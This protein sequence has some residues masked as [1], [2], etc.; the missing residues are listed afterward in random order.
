[1]QWE[2]LYLWLLPPIVQRYSQAS[3]N[4]QY[5]CPLKR[6][7]VS[8]CPLLA[9]S[10]ISIQVSVEN[11]I[12]SQT[13]GVMFFNT[14]DSSVKQFSVSRKFQV[15]MPADWKTQSL[16]SSRLIFRPKKCFCMHW[17][18]ELA[19]QKKEVQSCL[20]SNVIW[21]WNCNWELQVTKEFLNFYNY[22]EITVTECDFER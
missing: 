17:K 15:E 19:S 12:K 1:M 3:P 8:D 2:K 14:V 18:W 7:P 6:H 20:V 11:H 22:K 16:S 9:Q 10:E 13:T 4:L 21:S 5:P